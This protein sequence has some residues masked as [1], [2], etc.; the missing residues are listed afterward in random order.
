MMLAQ[1]AVRY[2]AI[3]LQFVSNSSMEPRPFWL[4]R[5]KT[6]LALSIGYCIRKQVKKMVENLLRLI[7]TCAYF[8]LE[9]LNWSGYLNEMVAVCR[10]PNQFKSRPGAAGFPMGDY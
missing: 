5:G 1:I 3:L 8:Y 6:S 10:Y 2:P 4:K 9:E 7:I